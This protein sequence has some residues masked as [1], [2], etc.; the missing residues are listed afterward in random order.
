MRYAIVSDIHANYQA[1]KAVLLDI[2]S[3]GADKIICLGDSVGYGPNPAEVLESLHESVDHFALGNHEAALCGKIDASSFNPE[4]QDMIAWTRHRVS[5]P[6]VRF[7]L[8]H[9]LAV[10]GPGFRCAHA[11]F[12][13]AGR[14][15]YAF[16]AA[17]AIPSWNAVEEPLL[18]IGHT[19]R[20][21]IMILGASGIP[22]M[23]PPED[24]LL[25][26]GKRFLVNVG[27][28]GQPRDGGTRSSYCLFDVEPGA[29]FWRQIPFDLDAFRE[30]YSRAGISIPPDSFLE[31]D[32]RKGYQPLRDQVHFRPPDS[33][34]RD[35]VDV[36][37]V[38]KLQRKVKTWKTL[39]AAGVL[40]LVLAVALAAGIW[41]REKK[42]ELLLPGYE[43]SAL[44]A[45]DF[46]PESNLLSFPGTPVDA[47]SPMPR[48]NVFLGD[49]Y[50]QRAAYARLEE[51]GH[52]F[53]LN[54]ANHDAEFRL[55]SAPIHVSPGMRI[56]MQGLLK[57]D[58]DFRGNV[59]FALILIQ[60]RDIPRTGIGP[61]PVSFETNRNFAVKEPNIKRQEGWALA[62]QT[63][64]MPARS[65]SVIFEVRGKFRG[66]AFIRD[67]RLEMK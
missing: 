35:T 13:D 6:A 58:G 10:A 40:L 45:A 18:F 30:A 16:E 46:A 44:R 53:V 60:Q 4:A 34:A 33:P 24:F 9:P 52:G 48:W 12:S 17:D 38:D 7:L 3:V 25:E 42:R 54:S 57:G 51:G 55:S 8:S 20:P 22:R 62:Q 5:G 2:R 36:Q 19:H 67:M 59:A 23:V 39:F 32:P 27:S 15:F 28:V 31:F 63:L 47:G 29:V 14:F 1:W 11:E 43:M 65:H 66:T 26:E 49:R 61:E 64:S 37:Y 21:C 50:S 41:T 56:R